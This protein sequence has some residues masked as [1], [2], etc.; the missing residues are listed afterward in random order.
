MHKMTM[1]HLCLYLFEESEED[2]GADG[3]LVRLIQHDDAVLHEVRV[4][5]AL[6]QQHAL[7]HVLNLCLWTRAVLETDRV[8]DLVTKN[9]V[10]IFFT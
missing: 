8:A 10:E 6:T 1:F 9:I 2:I 3:A 5:E 4:D 7:S